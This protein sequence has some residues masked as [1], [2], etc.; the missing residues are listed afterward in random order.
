MFVHS[1]H[2]HSDIE[3]QYNRTASCAL[4]CPASATSRVRCSWCPYG[5]PTSDPLP[6]C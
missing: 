3:L 1:P 2:R 4:Q 6:D 5:M